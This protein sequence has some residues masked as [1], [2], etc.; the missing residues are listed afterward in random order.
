MPFTSIAAPAAI[1]RPVC[2]DQA[3]S[4]VWGYGLVAEEIE[5]IDADKIMPELLD[6]E[7]TC[8]CRG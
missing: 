2:P 4:L 6:V 3:V 1:R 7:P 5:R 8:E